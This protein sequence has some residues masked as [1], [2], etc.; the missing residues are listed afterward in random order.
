MRILGEKNGVYL[1]T[2]KKK[3]DTAEAID[4]ISDIMKCPFSYIGIVS[5]DDLRINGYK[6]LVQEIAGH[7]DFTTHNLIIVKKER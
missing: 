2:P 1:F 5:A 7:I 6:D 3:E 4:K